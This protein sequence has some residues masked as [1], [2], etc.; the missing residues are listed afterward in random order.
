LTQPAI[1][2]I[3]IGGAILLVLLFCSLYFCFL[4]PPS[5]KLVAKNIENWT[6][7]DSGNINLAVKITTGGTSPDNL[8]KESLI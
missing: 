3:G 4:R 6:H 2:G 5:N 8:V 7:A 1:V